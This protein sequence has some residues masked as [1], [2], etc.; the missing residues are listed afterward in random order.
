MATSL[1]VGV[2][3]FPH[4]V[5]KVGFDPLLLAEPMKHPTPSISALL[6]FCLHVYVSSELFL[7]DEQRTSRRT[8]TPPPGGG[9]ECEVDRSTQPV[10]RRNPV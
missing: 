5:S 10:R 9:R 6:H 4:V 3:G 8:P 2:L 1:L 7:L